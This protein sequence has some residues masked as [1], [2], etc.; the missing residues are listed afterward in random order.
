MS[1]INCKINLN[2]KWS[3]KCFIVAS[4]TDQETT[5]LITDTKLYASVVILSNQDNAKLL[6]KLTEININQKY[7]QKD[8]I[9][10]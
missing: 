10:I 9:N 4:N 5:F 3:K 7:K 6:E 2:L 1:L 8:Q